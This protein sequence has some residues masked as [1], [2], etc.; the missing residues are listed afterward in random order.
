[1]FFGPS[2]VQLVLALADATC[3]PGNAFQAHAIAPLQAGHLLAQ[4]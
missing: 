2:P 1:M 3:A 4:P